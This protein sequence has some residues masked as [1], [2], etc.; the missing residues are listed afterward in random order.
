VGYSLGLEEINC[1][2]RIQRILSTAYYSLEDKKIDSYAKENPKWNLI[3]LGS[4]E[5]S[6]HKAVCK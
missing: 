4:V 5:D 6:L 1:E 2:S 3:L